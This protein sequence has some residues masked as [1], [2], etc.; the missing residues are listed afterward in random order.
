MEYWFNKKN[1]GVKP[2]KSRLIS[3]RLLHQ[4]WRIVSLKTNRAVKG[5]DKCYDLNI[6]LFGVHFSYTNFDYNENGD[7]KD[8]SN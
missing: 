3:L 2:Y 8:N 6:W 7:K 1:N 5:T 4:H